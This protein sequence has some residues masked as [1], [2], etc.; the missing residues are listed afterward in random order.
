MGR[1]WC[2]FDYSGFSWFSGLL[3]TVRGQIIV[4]QR[5]G[6]M[7][8]QM[9]ASPHKIV[10]STSPTAPGA[11]STGG[12]RTARVACEGRRRRQY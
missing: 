9:D 4:N 2:K 7:S 6:F 12:R 10:P 3:F 1:L 8:S 11:I 5:A